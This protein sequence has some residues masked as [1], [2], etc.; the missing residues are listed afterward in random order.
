MNR[1]QIQTRINSLIQDLRI[2][3]LPRVA[4]GLQKGYVDENQILVMYDHAVRIRVLQEYL[5][6]TGV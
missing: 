1:E 2:N 6:H 4:E 5:N 3:H